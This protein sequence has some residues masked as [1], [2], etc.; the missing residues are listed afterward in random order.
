MNPRPAALLITGALQDGFIRLLSHQGGMP[1]ISIRHSQGP[2]TPLCDFARHVFTFVA[3]LLQG[4]LSLLA[5][6]PFSIAAT[7]AR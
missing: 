6:H 5:Y 3:A 7:R 1:P 4:R 2:Y